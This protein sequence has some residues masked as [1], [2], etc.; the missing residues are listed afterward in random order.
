MEPGRPRPKEKDITATAFI[1][2]RWDSSRL[3][4]KNYLPCAG[5]SLV[6]RA[7]RVAVAARDIGLVQRVFVST[8][9]RV[10]GA[11]WTDARY[12]DWKARGVRVANRRAWDVGDL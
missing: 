5:E 9:E 1:P 6:S 4:H 8:D 7:I 12:D 3:A 10:T 2:A 11:G